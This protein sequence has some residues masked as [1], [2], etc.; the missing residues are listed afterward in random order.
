MSKFLLTIKVLTVFWLAAFATQGQ[1]EKVIADNGLTVE[2]LVET[3]AKNRL[4][5][6]SARQKLLI[7]EQ[8]I[9]RANLRPNPTLEGE[10]GT[11]RFFGDKEAEFSVGISQTFET[12]GK[13]AKRVKIAELELT[14]TKAEVLALEQQLFAEVRTA[15]AETLATGRLIDLQ[16]KLL[17]INDDILR[18]TNE[19]LKEGDVAPLELNLVKV[20]AD[21]LRIELVK[22]KGLLQNKLTG[23]KMLIGYNLEDALQLAPQNERPPRLDLGLA[24]LTA[25]A[26]RERADLQTLNL[27]TD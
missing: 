24:E 1:S 27:E 22:T 12:A 15:Y 3:A 23:F 8:K 19:R 25:T 11:N 13:R 20:E 16:E 14:K 5:I 9:R 21:L 6:A 4:D 7:A 10:Y 26:L 2:K 18:V 17:A